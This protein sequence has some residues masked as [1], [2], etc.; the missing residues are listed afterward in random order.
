VGEKTEDQ[1]SFFF[2]L[3][4]FSVHSASIRCQQDG[5]TETKGEEGKWQEGASNMRGITGVKSKVPKRFEAP[6][7]EKEKEKGKDGCL[8]D[9]EAPIWNH[10]P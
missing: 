2:S 7:G 4:L 10:A 1:K 3:L 5:K 6:R 8:D 9:S